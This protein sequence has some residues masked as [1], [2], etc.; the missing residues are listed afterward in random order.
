[1]GP[2]HSSAKGDLSPTTIATSKVLLV[3]LVPQLIHINP[4]VFVACGLEL[5]T[6][7]L[8]SMQRAAKAATRTRSPE[9]P[10]TGSADGNQPSTSGEGMA[11]VWYKSSGI[12][13]VSPSHAGQAVDFSKNWTVEGTKASWI[14]Q[15]IQFLVE[16]I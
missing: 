14:W 15:T 2:S 3:L 4:L 9:E 11:I 8:C 13:Q 5:G 1:M 7:A 6:K 12:L 10:A 16:G